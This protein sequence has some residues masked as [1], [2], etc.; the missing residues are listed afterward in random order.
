METPGIFTSNQIAWHSQAFG[1]PTKM[2]QCFGDKA[3]SYVFSASTCFRLATRKLA[4]EMLVLRQPREEGPSFSC[5][6]GCTNRSPQGCGSV[7]GL[8]IYQEWG[9]LSIELEEI[10]QLRRKPVS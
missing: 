5:G 4:A 10:A 6:A 8:C 1:D 9:S 3:L 7:Q 2:V